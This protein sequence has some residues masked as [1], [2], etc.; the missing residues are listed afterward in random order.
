MQNNNIN[1]SLLALSAVAFNLVFAANVHANALDDNMLDKKVDTKSKVKADSTIRTN[2]VK[3]N[4]RT[5][6]TDSSTKSY[7]SNSTDYNNGTNSKLKSNTDYDNSTRT[8]KNGTNGNSNNSSSSDFDKSN[9]YNNSSTNTNGNGI[10][11]EELT[12]QINDELGSGWFEEGYEGISVK[13]S[14]G[15]VTLQGTVPTAEDKKAVEDKV[16]N[17]KYV[18]SINSQIKINSQSSRVEKKGTIKV[19]KANDTNYDEDMHHNDVNEKQDSNNSSHKNDFSQDR[20]VTAAD[21]K[22]NKKIRDTVS[23]GWLWN[24]YK[25]VVLNTNNGV[26]TVEG[27]VESN[28]EQQKLLT[29]IQKVAGVKQVKS[30]LR[31]KNKK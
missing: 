6:D 4:I 24:S 10:S 1:K 26:V 15:N 22:L 23:V 8:N 11:D 5:N 14:Q 2:D 19:V 18:K 13:V 16:R 28:S 7:N 21:Q 12:K 30:N 27:T 9:S 31:I 25:E 29:D 20:G 17:I 3:S